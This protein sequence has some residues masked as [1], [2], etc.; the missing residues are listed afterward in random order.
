[1]LMKKIVSSLFLLLIFLTG[2]SNKIDFVE[3]GPFVQLQLY[4]ASQG[5]Y[6]DHFPEIITISSNGEVNLFTEEMVSRSGRV[7]MKVDEN[8]PKVEKKISAEE[9]EEIKEV[10]EKNKFFSLPTDVTD[11]GVM[12]GGGSK[13]TVY[14]KDQ[15]KTVGGENSNNDK[16]LEIRKIIFKQV[17][18][19]YYD[20]LEETEDYLFELNG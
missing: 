2:C 12:D 5:T 10:I 20:W 14:G 17:K 1:M 7:D 11:Y 13:I 6:L 8:V 9:V 19:E 15:E 4:S 16:Y 18:D 3:E